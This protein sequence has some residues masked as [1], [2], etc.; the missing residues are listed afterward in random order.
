M[1]VM[2]CHFPHIMSQHTRT[3][4]VHTRGHTQQGQVK[5]A[6]V[7]CAAVSSL[8]FGC[9]VNALDCVACNKIS[10]AMRFMHACSEKDARRRPGRIIAPVEESLRAPDAVPQ[11][12]GERDFSGCVAEIIMRLTVKPRNRLA[13][14]Q[15]HADS[16]D[17]NSVVIV[18]GTRL[19]RLVEAVAQHREHLA[20]RLQLSPDLDA[21]KKKAGKKYPTNSNVPYFALGE[22]RNP[23]KD[24]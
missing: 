16:H 5:A 23:S 10:R 3:R 1:V 8:P 7:G 6:R 22:T 4:R 9:T 19:V 17:G 20:N 2:T 12:L 15:T 13:Q 18:M 24:F 11:Y 14:T 21:R